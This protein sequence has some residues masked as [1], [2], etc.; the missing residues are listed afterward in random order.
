MQTLWLPPV[1]RTDEPDWD[2][3]MGDNRRDIETPTRRFG[4]AVS[5][6]SHLGKPL[7][8]ELWQDLM[9]RLQVRQLCVIRPNDEVKTVAPLVRAA[10]VQVDEQMNVTDVEYWP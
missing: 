9:F 7:S 6:A 2:S 5:F 1:E 4:G 3:F 10:F 8:R